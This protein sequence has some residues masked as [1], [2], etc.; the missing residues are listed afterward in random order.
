MTKRANPK[1]SKSQQI[2]MSADIEGM[3]RSGD[4][5]AYLI[6]N[7]GLVG[8]KTARQYL[9]MWRYEGKKLIPCSD[10]KR[11]SFQTGCPGHITALMPN[12]EKM[13]EIESEWKEY[14][15]NEDGK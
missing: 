8:D 5:I 14:L 12:D 6:V 2:H 15:N 11:F 1:Y 4:K 7:G 9:K 10:C 13:I 3:L